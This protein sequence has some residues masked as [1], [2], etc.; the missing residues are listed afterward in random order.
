MGNIRAI[1]VNYIDNWI[2]SHDVVLA[3]VPCNETQ[4]GLIDVTQEECFNY[5]L[6][7]AA[8]AKGI[9]SVTSQ[10]HDETEPAEPAE[11]EFYLE[12]KM[13]MVPHFIDVTGHGEHMRPIHSVLT[14]YPNNN[15]FGEMHIEG[16]GCIIKAPA[17]IEEFTFPRR[18]LKYTWYPPVNY[19]DDNT[20]ICNDNLNQQYCQRYQS[21]S[22]GCV[23]DPRC[24]VSSDVCLACPCTIPAVEGKSL[25][26]SSYAGGL[27]CGDNSIEAGKINVRVCKISPDSAALA[28]AQAKIDRLESGMCG[29]STESQAELK[30]ALKA[31]YQHLG[32]CNSSV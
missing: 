1:D 21:N 7:D 26:Q 5:F 6:H 23:S 27:F 25:S 19:G 14:H 31:A 15:I 9:L 13:T 11:P 24:R 16:G 32:Y 18:V 3:N 10:S 8:N 2:K 22:S 20:K 29:D 28:A 4:Y 17:E 12:D 30:N